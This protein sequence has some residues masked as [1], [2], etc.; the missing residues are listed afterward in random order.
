MSFY[1]NIGQ[2]EVPNPAG[3]EPL[4]VRTPVESLAWNSTPVTWTD[5]KTTTGESK[6][7]S[8]SSTTSERH[9]SGRRRINTINTTTTNNRVVASTESTSTAV[10]ISSSSTT[11][12]TLIPFMRSKRIKFTSSGLKPNAKLIAKFAGEDVTRFCKQTSSTRPAGVLVAEPTGSLVGYFDL[13]ANQ[14]KVGE[15]IFSV[16]D[17]TD[18]ELSNAQTQYTAIGERLDTTIV[19]KHDTVITIQKTITD[20]T[21]VNTSTRTT[22]TRT[23]RRWVDP[24]AQSFFVDTAAGADGAFIHSIDLFFFEVDPKHEVKVEIRRMRDGYPTLDLIYPYAF[25]K[26]APS[27]ITAT[28]NGTK[29]TRFTFETPVYLQGG[30]EYAFVVM[31]NSEKTSMWCAELGKKSFTAKDTIAPSGELIAKQPYLGTMFMSQNNSTWD[32]IQLRDVKFIINRCKFSKSAGKITYVNSTAGD[33]YNYPN[34][35]FMAPNALEF[36][37]GS[38]TVWLYAHGHAM[39]EGDV[40]RLHF[41]NENLPT[42]FGIAKT[43]I[44]NVP[45]TVTGTTAT[46]ISFVVPKSA[47]G[48]G[49]S[50]GSGMWMDGWVVGYSYAQLI[51]KD[52]ALDNTTITYNLSS[53]PQLNYTATEKG[54]IPLVSNRVVELDAINVI[55]KDNDRGAVIK[56]TISTINDM[57]SPMVYSDSI[58]IE[59]HMNIINNI[60]YQ[61]ARGVK[62]ED[63]SPSKYIQREVNLIN[64]ANELKV[65][66]ESS[67][68]YGSN[69]SVYY[70]CGTGEIDPDTDW[71][72]MEHENGQPVHSLSTDDWRT[73]KFTKSFTTEWDVFQVMLVLYSD[74][75]LVIP[76]VKNYRAIALNV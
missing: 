69:I 16:E 65:Y 52:I 41:F 46:K 13:P 53:K 58:G 68:I 27:Q 55:K 60:D 40:F 4:F 28:V 50:G 56:S 64:A 59:G 32:A 76:K 29:K 61:N 22:S 15:R 24:V 31:S 5:N 37:Q 43:Q 51:K 42:M 6:T 14:F 63:S 8:T 67:M 47:N 20:S 33:R 75:R 70:K 17:A 12:S 2:T 11:K 73:Q 25:A 71:V 19:N 10:T 3:G 48:S 34:K 7:T 26:L 72:K 62:L 9:R 57:I 38:T 39:I 30:D 21:T 23:R 45:L 35:K 54:N 74:S 36:T 49:S 18:R 44:E 1:N 66:F